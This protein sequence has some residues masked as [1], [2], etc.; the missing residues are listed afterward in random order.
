MSATP[1]LNYTAF[2]WTVN[3]GNEELHA[4]TGYIAVQP[5]SSRA[6]MTTVMSNGFV[7]VEEG[8]VNSNRIRFRLVDIGRISF[9]RDLPVHDVSCN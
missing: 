6:S 4:E 9:S 3:Q 5:G 2:A 8:P 7:T 1:A